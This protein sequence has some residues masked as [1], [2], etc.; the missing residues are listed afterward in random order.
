MRCEYYAAD[1]ASLVQWLSSEAVLARYLDESGKELGSLAEA[2]LV[3]HI[4]CLHAVVRHIQTQGLEGAC[5]R[6]R[7]LVDALLTDIFAWGTFQQWSD[8]PVAV[9]E[10]GDLPLEVVQRGLLGADM[11]DQ[12]ALLFVPEPNVIALC[13][14]REPSAQ[15]LIEREV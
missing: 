1:V 13:R 2:P 3:Q 15:E 8:I 7:S 10:E 12:G 6:D 9:G 11:A 5:E 4:R 14:Q